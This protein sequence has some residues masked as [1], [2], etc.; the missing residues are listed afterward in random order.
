LTI[1][2]RGEGAFV[3]PVQ[4]LV[5]A[6]LVAAPNATIGTAVDTSL[7]TM[8]V[9]AVHATRG[10]IRVGKIGDGAKHGCISNSATA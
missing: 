3:P 1:Y 8:H 10:A 9:P 5:A 2:V 6:A 4:A 7:G